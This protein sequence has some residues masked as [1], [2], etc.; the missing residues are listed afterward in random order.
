M[1]LRVHPD[2]HVYLGEFRASLEEVRA[3]RPGF[4]V[5]ANARTLEYDGAVSVLIDHDGRQGSGPLPWRDGDDLLANAEA[6]IAE[7]QSARPVL[8][9]TDPAP[10]TPEEQVDV[11]AMKRLRGKMLQGSASPAEIQDALARLLAR[12]IR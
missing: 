2:G 9:P 1:K 6:I 7:V 12:F 11:D 8:G 4:A 10:L 3:L 5:P